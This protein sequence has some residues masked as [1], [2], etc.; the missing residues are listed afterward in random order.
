MW[1]R[2]VARAYPQL[3]VYNMGSGRYDPERIHRPIRDVEDAARPKADVG[4]LERA[5]QVG[6]PY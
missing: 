1:D 2:V 5:Q 4:D 3:V 6:H